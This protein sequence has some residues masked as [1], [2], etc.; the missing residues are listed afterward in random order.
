MSR[1]EDE[2]GID[3]PFNRAMDRLDGI[4]PKRT[5]KAA[6]VKTLPRITKAVAQHFLDCIEKARTEERAR[7]SFAAQQARDRSGADNFVD[8]MALASVIGSRRYYA[9]PE[10]SRRAIDEALDA[11]RAK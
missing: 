11:I 3:G 5:R 10:G 6:K 9:D 7:P 1:L 4:K 8:A 2:D